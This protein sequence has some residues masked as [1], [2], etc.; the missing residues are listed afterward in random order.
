MPL[1]A[2]APE[3]G[4]IAVGARGTLKFPQNN[5]LCQGKWPFD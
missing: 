5:V 4:S 1:Y 2:V 3:K